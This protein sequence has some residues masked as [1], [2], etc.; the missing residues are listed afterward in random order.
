MFSTSR[1]AHLGIAVVMMATATKT[2]L[3]A[4]IVEFRYRPPQVGQHGTHEM[5]FQ[6]DLNIAM[7][8]A[9]KTISSEAQQLSRDQQREMTILEVTDKHATKVEVVYRKAQEIVGRGNQNGLPQTQPIEGKSYLVERHADDLIV[10]DLQGQAVAEEE[11]TLVAASMQSVG[12]PSP[13]GQL[14]NGKK[15][16][17]GQTLRLPNEMAADVLGMK[18]TG[19]EPQNVNLMLCE[20]RQEDGRRLAN[21]DLSITLKLTGGGSLEIKGDLQIEP[22][23]CQIAAANFSGPV[24]MREEHGP[25]GHTFEVQSEGTMKVAVRSR[26]I[27]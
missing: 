2:A 10:T 24:S 12:R 4:D 18:D 27:R 19:G 26:E 21:F 11:R 9:G 23:T 16:A 13:L 20:V 22:E 15:L 3:A 14:L 1:F 8:Q 5:Q 17:V 7:R 6:L 25:T